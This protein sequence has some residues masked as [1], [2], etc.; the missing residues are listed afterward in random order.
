MQP[1]Q[2]SSLNICPISN[3]TPSSAADILAKNV[4]DIYWNYM[5]NAVN[6]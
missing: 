2:N 6:G 3:P 1:V 4:S 5:Q